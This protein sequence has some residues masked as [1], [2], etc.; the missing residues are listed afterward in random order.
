[1]LELPNKPWTSP[2]AAAILIFLLASSVGYY[3]VHLEDVTFQVRERNRVVE[4]VQTV[5]A[6]LEREI[7][8][9]LSAL[10]AFEAL[11][12]TKPD[13]QDDE[14]QKISSVLS[15]G[16]PLIREIQLSPNGIVKYVYPESAAGSVRGLNLLTLPDQRTVVLQTIQQGQVWLAGPTTLVQGGTGLIARDPI[17]LGTGKVRRFWGFVTVLLDYPKFVRHIP[18]LEDDPYVEF[19]I[20]GKDGMGA[21]GEVFFGSAEIFTHAPVIADVFLPTG[22]WQVAGRPVGGWHKTPLNN[23]ISRTL[24][25]ISILVMSALAYII[26]MRGLEMERIATTDV[27]TGTLRRHAFIERTE[28]EIHRI[29]RYKRP[30]SLISFDLDHFKSVNDRWGHASGD[31]VLKAVTR[32]VMERLRPSDVLGR[33][34]GE[35]FA[36]LCPETGLEQALV[37]AERIR[38]EVVNLPMV[39][40]PD[41][42]FLTVSLGVVEFGPAKDTLQTMMSAADKALYKS[43]N[44]GR[45]RVSVG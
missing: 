25:F 1:M 17:Y 2:L 21:K 9:N 12:L 14:F 16:L 30:L 45:N 43:K 28:G 35:E 7:S 24:I 37:L 31:T 6:A 32:R 29:Q 22:L 18:I 8:L 27:L 39:F 44:E 4:Q 19:A 33:I 41:R 34:G 20:R 15:R 26:R 36:I 42:V 3:L 10:N 5:R 40:G 23:T 38:E 11:I 13:I